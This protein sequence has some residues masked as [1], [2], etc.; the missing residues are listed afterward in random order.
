MTTEHPGLAEIPCR[1]FLKSA[2]RVLG[3]LALA[4]LFG[5]GVSPALADPCP[6]EDGDG[7]GVDVS[8]CDDTGLDGVGDCNDSD[9]DVNPGHVEL[10]GDLKDND[11]DGDI[12]YGLL[13]D[14]FGTPTPEQ[15]IYV[16]GTC[17]LS[18]PPG[19]VWMG[20]PPMPPASGCCLTAGHKVCN[21]DLLGVHCE[22]NTPDGSIIEQETEGPYN[23]ATCFDLKDNDCDMHY[24]H[25]DSECTGP[26]LCNG[27][28]D[29]NDGM[30]DEIFPLG[31]PCTVGV[32]ACV[33]NGV[34]VCDGMGGYRCNKVP[35]APGA[36][37]TPGAA[38]C[39]DGLDNDCDG[40]TDLADPSCQEAEKCDGADNDG[41]GS[42]DESFTD[43]GDACSVGQGACQAA[44]VQVCTADGAGTTCDAVPNLGAAGVE[45]P[46]GA[47]CGDGIDNDC[48]GLTDGGDPGCGS[49]GLHVT[50]ALPLITG[51][52]NGSSCESWSNIQYQVTGGGP[53]VVVTAEL[54]AVAETGELLAVLPVNKGDTA[55]LNSRLDPDDWKW[56]SRL[57]KRAGGNKAAAGMW[58]DMFAP[59]P[60][61]RVHARDSLNEAVAY[62]SI[63][64]Y[65]DVVKPAGGVVDG[66]AEDGGTTNVLAAL[67]L[68]SVGSLEVLV[69]GVD[70]FDELGIDPAV[71]FPGT[72]PGGVVMIGTEAVTI[73]DIAVDIAPNIFTQSSNT[74][75][76]NITGLACGGNEV[77]VNGVGVF[78]AGTQLA[79]TTNCHVDDGHDCGSTAVFDLTIDAPTP[80]QIVPT[81]PT[82]VMGEVCHGLPIVKTSI[83]GKQLDTSTQTMTGS[84][85]ECAG[86]TYRYTIDTTLPQTNLFAESV[87]ATT[88]LGTFDPGSNRLI[89]SAVDDD[90]HRIFKSFLF[91]VGN[92]ADIIPSSI[93]AGPVSVER[94]SKLPGWDFGALRPSANGGFQLTATTVV[95]SFVFGLETEALDTFFAAT[96]ADASACAEESLLQQVCDF[97]KNNQT[98]PID[99]AC[100][101][102]VDF[103]AVG[104]DPGDGIP[105]PVF[106]GDFTCHVTAMDGPGPG[107]SGG[108]LTVALEVPRIQ[109]RVRATGGCH[110]GFLWGA[111][112]DVDMEVEI[113]LPHPGDPGCN[114]GDSNVC[115]DPTM[116]TEGCCIPTQPL[117]RVD[118]SIEE[119]DFMGGA[120]QTVCK[121]GDLGCCD[122]T[123]PG[124]VTGVFVPSGV[125]KVT[126]TDGG[127]EAGGWNLVVLGILLIVVGALLF[128]AGP[129]GIA[130][131]IVLIALGAVI[132]GTLAGGVGV[133]P[134][135]VFTPDLFKDMNL[136][137][138]FVVIPEVA[139]NEDLYNA[140]DKE[141]VTST[142]EIKV[143]GSGL[144]A[145]SDLTISATL[146]DPSVPDSPGFFATPAPPPMTPIDPGNTFVTIS[147]DTLNAVLAAATT[148]GEM[149][150][151]G[152]S[153]ALS[154]GTCCASD[155][156]KTLGS[157]FPADCNDITDGPPIT[158]CTLVNAI[159]GDI[160]GCMRVVLI[161]T[162]LG[163]QAGDLS[164]TAASNLCE[165]YEGN[166]GFN[167][168]AEIVGQAVCHGVRGANCSTIP[169]PFLSAG[170]ERQLC[171]NIP[172]LHVKASDEILT[173][174]RNDNPPA[175][176]IK[177]Q[178]MTAPVEAM[179]RLNDLRA[180]F[181]V[182][183]DGDGFDG[184]ELVGVPSCLDDGTTNDCRLVSLC[185]DLNLEASMLLAGT[186]EMPELMFNIG[187]V[188]PLQRV[189]G[190]ACEG[191]VDFKYTSDAEAAG[192]ATSSDSVE[193]SLVE[194]TTM[195]T[196]I[197]RPDGISLGGLVTFTNPEIFAIK[198]STSPGR[199]FNNLNMNC[200]T[201][202]D[203]GGM[204][205][206]QFQDYLGVRGSI[207]QTA[208]PSGMC[209]MP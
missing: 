87:G 186:N 120:T 61:L 122:P 152:C 10:C 56:V 53:D 193:D 132:L 42:V 131:G 73:S 88:E 71:A 68:T 12:D 204:E 11:C 108:T 5:A 192:E 180:G 55:H 27:F 96:C 25:D 57:N 59:V 164:P 84:G 188:M 142:P 31:D 44:G 200:T 38:A 135:E 6:D 13:V 155:P 151:E 113:V 154:T 30:V 35:G 189:E 137:E 149:T 86:A 94:P 156:P 173:C 148:Q 33:R 98:I 41:D 158:G 22:S 208:P 170:T 101:P 106:L 83:N 105:D 20:D 75:T 115:A 184:G 185:L 28:D 127:V 157:L 50:C 178:P 126:I 203:C 3:I 34:Y 76:M 160:T 51:A 8:G 133:G 165:S 198:T 109:F 159:S 177:D 111:N 9:P 63:V 119:R 67:P 43:L 17:S 201:N 19:C 134:G 7:W 21:M 60:L 14:S 181:L 195:A 90:A 116:P 136:V 128:F 121:D 107:G 45:G 176:L 24:D 89:A 72:H 95:D 74:L 162:C 183:R 163:I 174:V 97:S 102:E 124:C 147:D 29:D 91:A 81:I 54:W 15:D 138:I 139:P 85:L 123:V 49:A 145:T 1:S 93:V 46:A 191:D 168:V 26:E 47:T 161:G 196:P 199:C 141:I 39:I 118:I 18:D 100:D 169:I 79:V 182:D 117:N 206:I 16:G 32:G 197:Q 70:I 146:N 58:H 69:N 150:S 153:G 202:A 82:P 78:P 144:T 103:R 209:E 80:G 114:P 2:S 40:T 130:F 140:T 179:L 37:N 66:T 112:V 99:G 167:D 143:T 4:T 125:I 175:F 190:E 52:P 62:C 172:P 166:A 23:T 110:G 207:E 194:N 65:L 171:Q 129:V 77:V 187:A 205:C 64:P 104:C 36:E 48:D 92:P